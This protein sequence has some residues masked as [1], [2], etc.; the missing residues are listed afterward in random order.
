MMIQGHVYSFAGKPL[1]A[2]AVMIVDSELRPAGIRST[3]N[4]A[5]MFALVG[6]IQAGDFILAT[7]PG[8]RSVVIP[9]EKSTA[10]TK[11]ILPQEA[12][13]T[14]SKK[15]PAWI[16]LLALAAIADNKKKKAVGKVDP[17]TV[18]AI[19]L[20]GAGVLGFG[21][22][23]ELLESLGIWKSKEE[24]NL[25]DQQQNPYSY[26]SPN[27]YKAAP[28]GALLLTT[29]W[30]KELA[31]R[32]Y[33]AFGAFNDDEEVPIGQIKANIRT[34]SQFSFLCD[35]FYKL[36]GTDLLK[37]LIG[38]WWPQDRLSAQDVDEINQ[39]ISRLPK[40]NT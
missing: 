5:G 17:Q 32:I 35:M 1:G 14:G 10:D 3:T 7:A 12:V 2:A 33:N 19:V 39:Y 9:V 31:T 11:F 38:G 29:S 40:Y 37:F 34:Q 13:V 36:Y 21:L 25:D 22:I 30:A 24:K 8:F 18:I 23:R 15:F 28:A 26:W 4:A 6:D 16:A 27:F 20:A